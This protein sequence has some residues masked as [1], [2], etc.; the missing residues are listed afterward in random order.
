MQEV[1]HTTRHHWTD[2]SAKIVFV[3][4]PEVVDNWHSQANQ[5]IRIVYG[6]LNGAAMDLEGLDGRRLD[7]RG[8]WAAGLPLWCGGAR[9]CELGDIGLHVVVI[10]ESWQI[11]DA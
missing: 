2:R 1:S 8:L 6:G 11:V 3:P 4:A 5:P 7:W 10:V 9:C